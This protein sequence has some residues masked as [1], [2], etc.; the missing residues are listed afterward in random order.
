MHLP[1][2]HLSSMPRTS[3]VGGGLSMMT[4]NGT[5]TLTVLRGA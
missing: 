3:A 2:D 4:T 1:V 5:I